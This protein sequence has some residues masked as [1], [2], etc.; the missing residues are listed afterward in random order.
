MIIKCIDEGVT[1]VAGMGRN[2][3]V[4]GEKCELNNNRGFVS[5]IEFTAYLAVLLRPSLCNNNAISLLFHAFQ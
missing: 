1:K 5:C 4:L 3:M 2:S